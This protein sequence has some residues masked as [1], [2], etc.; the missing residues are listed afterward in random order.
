MRSIAREII[1][2]IIHIPRTASTEFWKKPLDLFE[3]NRFEAM[4]AR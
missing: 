1:Q 4:I 3:K 2:I